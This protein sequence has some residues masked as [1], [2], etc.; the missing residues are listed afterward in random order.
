MARSIISPRLIRGQLLFQVGDVLFPTFAQAAC[1]W[2]AAI[3]A[4]AELRRQ[5]G[6]S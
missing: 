5:G 2:V 3:E 4:L 6:G 1:A